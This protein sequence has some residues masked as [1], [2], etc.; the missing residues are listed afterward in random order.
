VRVLY[1]AILLCSLSL[2]FAL[3]G[4]ASTAKAV[5]LPCDEAEVAECV[6]VDGELGAFED[7]EVVEDDEFAVEPEDELFEGDEGDFTDFADED[8]DGEPSSRDDDDDDDGVRDARDCDR[9]NDGHVDA[10]DGDDDGDGIA[11]AKDVDDDNDGLLDR[12]DADDD[13]DGVPDARESRHRP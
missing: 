10:R 13:N 8:G 9:D 4:G 11:D 6:D 7:E 3:S 2:A 1:P 5:A 12:P